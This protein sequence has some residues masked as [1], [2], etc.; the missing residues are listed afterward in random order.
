MVPGPSVLFVISRGV[1]LGRRAAL[2]TVLGNALGAFCV[3]TL[4]AFGLGPLVTRSVWLYNGIKLLG[5]GYLLWLGWCAFRDRRELAMLPD[6]ATEPKGVQRIIRE[7]FV[8]GITNPKVVV[9]FSAILPQF[10][11][12]GRGSAT[13]QMLVL[14]V[15]FTTIALVSDGLWGIL[16]GSVRRWFLAD[17]RRLRAVVGTGGIAIMGLGAR[18]ALTRRAE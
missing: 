15:I 17:A 4:V 11:D 2:A 6:A 13:A 10:V 7:G 3:G 16:A 5:A 8:V 1:A 12:R 18:L 9:F 14:L